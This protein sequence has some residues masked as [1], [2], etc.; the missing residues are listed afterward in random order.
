MKRHTLSKNQ[1]LLDSFK[2]EDIGSFIKKLSENKLKIIR[3]LDDGYYAAAIAR[4]LNLSRSY[5]SRFVNELQFKGMISL[6]WI[7]PLTRRAKSYRVIPELKTHLDRLKQ[8]SINFS[9]FTPHKIRYKYKLQEKTKPISLNTGRFAAAK[10]KHERTYCMAGGVRNVFNMRHE[11]AGNIGI[12]VHPNSIEVYQRDRQPISS[13]S[14][15][16]ATN[17]LAIAIN[18]VAQRFAQEQEWE[19][20]HFSLGEPVMVGSPHYAGPSRLARAITDNGQTLLPLSAGFEVDRS[21]EKKFGEKKTADLE[22]DDIDAA[23]IMDRGIKNAYNIETIV[24]V[25]VKEELKSVSDQILGLNEQKE[26][27]DLMASNVQALCQSGL[28]LTNQFNQLTGIVSQQGYQI[29]KI[30]ETILEL[31]KNMSKIIDKMELKG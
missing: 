5:V 14:L 17:Q 3:L 27:I 10:V 20:V 24:P 25:L 6:E 12:T 29:T 1:V 16:D 19:S 11:R 26:K 2:G 8:P 22:T 21:L 31:I 18:D 28:P 30:Q 15:E 23:E 7:N 9:L 4:R 13:V